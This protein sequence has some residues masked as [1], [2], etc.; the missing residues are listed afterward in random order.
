LLFKQK[1]QDPRSA[2]V[3]KKELELFCKLNEVTEVLRENGLELLLH[4][5]SQFTT[6]K[7]HEGEIMYQPWNNMYGIALDPSATT[8]HT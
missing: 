2:Y 6:A 4:P 5:L 8:H 1:A 3:V 7:L